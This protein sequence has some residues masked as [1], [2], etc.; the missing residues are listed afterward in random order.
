MYLVIY[1]KG[2]LVRVSGVNRQ[3]GYREGGFRLKALL[4]QAGCFPQITKIIDSGFGFDVRTLPSPYK[5]LRSR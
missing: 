2:T 5:K 1:S 4:T 3:S